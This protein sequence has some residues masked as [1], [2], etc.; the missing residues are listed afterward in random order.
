ML[1][2]T[3]G[4][5]LVIA[6]FGGWGVSGAR[7]LC[8]RVKNLRD[9]HMALA[10]LEKEITC[11]YSPLSQAL[12]NTARCSPF[13]VSRL[14][15]GSAARLRGRAGVTAREAWLQGI[16]ELRQFSQ[17]QDDDYEL[18]AAAAYQLGASDADQ[19]RKFLESLQEQLKISEKKASINMESGQK[20]WT[21]GG[22]LAGLLVVL[23]L[24]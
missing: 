19:Q 2:K 8:G 9:L 21:Y 16:A 23:L 10:F 6:G 1:I 17:L 13:P 12:E 22:F 7:R 20:L 14:F 3:I 15:S 24:L 5:V 11:M 4:M 18:L